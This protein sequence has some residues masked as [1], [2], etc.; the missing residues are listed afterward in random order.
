MTR[1]HAA[2]LQLNR[3][4]LA[5]ATTGLAI[6]T[7]MTWPAPAASAAP[8]WD[9]DG[10]TDA[11]CRALDPAVHPG[12][13]DHPD[14]AFEDLNCDGIDGD[15]A[16]AY[17]VAPSGDDTSNPGTSA[18]PFRTIQ[19]AIT[20]AAGSPTKAIYVATGTYDEHL[21]VGPSGDGIRIHGGY[22]AGTWQ[23]TTAAATT[24][25]GQPEAMLLDGA[26]DVVRAAG[27]AQR[28]ARFRSVRL[29][30]ARDKRLR[31]GGDPWPRHRPAPVAPAPSGAAEATPSKAA[32][33]AAGQS[34]TAP[35]AATNHCD[36]AGMGGSSSQ[37]GN[38]IDG[39]A[40]GTGGEETNDG[41]NGIPAR[42]EAAAALAAIRERAVLDTPGDADNPADGENGDTGSD[43]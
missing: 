30:A 28:D 35:G 22:Q 8:D 42:R 19:K 5:V 11:D 41:E 13:V 21:A 40:G 15:E 27:D 16:N 14:L 4:T 34:P 31:G 25:N 9:G 43:R 2:R 10:A 32:N 6:A 7:A 36:F 17:F 20:T 37:P 1:N 26:T 39:G 24:V 33:G 18:F 38:G 23:R 3:A 29:R 12:A